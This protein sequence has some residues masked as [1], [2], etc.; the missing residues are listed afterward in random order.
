MEKPQS[1]TNEFKSEAVKLV[2][3]QGLSER[4]AAK[5]LSMPKGTLSNW[6]RDAKGG[7]AIANPGARSVPEL[8]AEVSKLRKELAEARMERDILKKATAYFAKEERSEGFRCKVRVHEGVATRIPGGGDG[9]GAGRFA[10]RVLRVARPPAFAPGGRGR[11]AEGGDCRRPR[12]DPRNLWVEAPAGRT[13]RRW[14]CGR[15][16]PDRPILANATEP[17]CPL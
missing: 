8:E 14:L 13:G 4:V 12:E 11:A 3:D 7:K 17:Q 16:G 6:V 15:T 10:R 5:R 2:L 9:A 1:Y